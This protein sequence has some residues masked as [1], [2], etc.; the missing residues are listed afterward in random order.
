MMALT[1]GTPTV[2]WARCAAAAAAGEVAPGWGRAEPA[3][4]SAVSATMTEATPGSALTTA[5]AR[6]RTGSQA[7][8]TAASTVMEKN[9]LPSETTMSDR[10]PVLGKASPS[11]LATRS[12]LA[13][14]SLFVSAI[15]LSMT[16]AG[17]TPRGRNVYTQ[18][19]TGAA[20]STERTGVW[21]FPN[22]DHLKRSAEAGSALIL[23]F[24]LGTGDYQSKT[25]TTSSPQLRPA[26]L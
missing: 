26:L 24:P 19:G 20:R 10:A 14:T 3:E 16:A 23:E 7:F 2:P 22:A 9:T 15:R 5:S 4:R 13:R 18:I 1:P 11:G 21:R 6:L 17:Q 12:R 25:S 8:T